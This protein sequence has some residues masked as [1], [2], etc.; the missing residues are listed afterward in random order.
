MS[1][2]PFAE[3]GIGETTALLMDFP[4]VPLRGASYRAHARVAE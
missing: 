3:K 4:N 2:E 1:V